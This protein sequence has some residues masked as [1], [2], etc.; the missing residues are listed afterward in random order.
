MSQGLGQS[1]SD[2]LIK[3]L[4]RMHTSLSLVTLQS[5]PAKPNRKSGRNH[6]LSPSVARCAD[7]VK[8]TWTKAGCHTG[9][10]WHKCTLE[11]GVWTFWTKVT[12]SSFSPQLENVLNARG[13]STI[14]QCRQVEAAGCKLSQTRP[15]CFRLQIP[16]QLFAHLHPVFAVY[17]SLFHQSH[18]SCSLRSLHQKNTLAIQ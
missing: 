13:I 5:G 14:R 2:C 11:S 12:R 6:R 8:A 9:H 15:H 4:P 17:F 18:D 7:A 3:P 16:T 1:V 10:S